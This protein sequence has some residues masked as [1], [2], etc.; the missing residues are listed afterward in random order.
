MRLRCIITTIVFVLAA[1]NGFA[2]TDSILVSSKDTIRYKYTPM[3]I[4]ADIAALANG[5]VAESAADDE[6]QR[7]AKRGR[8]VRKF[9][10]FLV[11]SVTDESFE[12]KVD[13]S[14]VLFPYYTPST[15]LG[16]GASVTGLYRLDKRNRALPPSSF[17]IVA[18]GSINGTYRVE[19]NGVNIFKDGKDRLFYRVGFQSLPTRLWGLGYEAA[20]AG[21]YVSY[22]GNRWYAEATYL[23]RIVKNIYIGAQIDFDYAFCGR[24]SQQNIIDRLDGQR[25]DYLSTGISLLAEY[26]SRNSRNAPNKGFYVSLKGTVR[27]EPLGTVGRT[28]W[29]ATA[30]VD[31]YQRLWR[32]AVLAIDLYGEFNSRHT[33]WT[34]YA[35]LGDAQRMRGYYEGRFMDLNLISAQ[36]ELRQTV[37]QRLGVAV[38]GGA[39]NVFHSFKEF[40]WNR[41]LP[42]YGIGL[43][44]S[45]NSNSSI[46]LD[47]GFGKRINGAL[48]GGFIFSVNEAF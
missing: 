4:P 25:G 20:F 33:P 15:S 7:K 8:G 2:Q 40:S 30:I 23:R 11:S 44:W 43:R 13:F 38:W 9:A 12:K 41:T 19:A 14:F 46:R 32:G 45:V 48:S 10:D 26:D 34:L 28:L 1:H 36:V 27:P 22:V 39:G 37:W 21:D 6:A 5:A 17:S 16:L 42:S 29:S 35:R 18:N 47:Y 31:Y 3:T 24:N